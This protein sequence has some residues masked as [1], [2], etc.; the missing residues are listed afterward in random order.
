MRVFEIMVLKMISMANRK[1]KHRNKEDYIMS[2][3]IISTAQNI[4]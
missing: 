3:F 2:S 1:R 4:V